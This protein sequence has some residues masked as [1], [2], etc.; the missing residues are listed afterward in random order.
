MTLDLDL[1]DRIPLDSLDRQQLDHQSLNE[2]CLQDIRHN[3]D[4]QFLQDRTHN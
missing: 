2:T 4:Q 3:L 1:P